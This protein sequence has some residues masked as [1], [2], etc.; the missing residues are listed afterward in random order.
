MYLGGKAVDGDLPGQ[1]Q[2]LGQVLH[3]KIEGRVVGEYPHRVFIDLQP[4]PDGFHR[5]GAVPVR[6]DPVQRCQ[7]QVWAE[8]QGDE[9]Q[10]FQQDPG[11]REGGALSQ[12]PGDQ[13]K[14]GDVVPT[15][16]LRPI[17]GIAGEVQSCHAQAP[18]VGGLKVEGI[19]FRRQGRADQGVMVGQF[20]GPPEGEGIIPG[21]DGHRLPVG[22]GEIQRSPEIMA[23]GLIGLI[24]ERGTHRQHLHDDTG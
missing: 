20:S 23:A 12:N 24:G 22:G 6:Q 9:I 15:G 8:G 19:L 14:G 18:F 7:G 5:Q 3:L 4:L 11:L 13:L 17:G 16:N 10:P 21:R 2:K 1:V